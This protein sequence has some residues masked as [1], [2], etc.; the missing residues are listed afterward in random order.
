MD[1]RLALAWVKNCIMQTF[2][3]QATLRRPPAVLVSYATCLREFQRHR[4]QL[5]FRDWMLDSGAFSAYNRGVPIDL[6]AYIALCLELRATDTSLA[7]IIAL[8]VIGDGV[9]SLRNAR[10]MQ[11]RGVEAMPVFHVGEDWGL[12]AEYCAG[13][14]KVGLSCR[15]GEPRS[16][17][18]RFYDQCF[19]RH[20]PHRFHSFGWVEEQMLLRFPFHSADASS[21]MLAPKAFGNWQQWGHVPIRGSHSNNLVGEVNW[22]LDLE[23]RV[24]ERWAGVYRELTGHTP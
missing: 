1:L 5:Q 24:N 6:D 20:W 13:W 23:S 8:D 2:G 9:G 17:S 15:F 10:I 11:E 7:E 18:Y 4:G 14:S 16:S 22:Y 21:W 12:L 3:P 19:A